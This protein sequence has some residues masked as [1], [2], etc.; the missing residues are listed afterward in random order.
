VVIKD[1]QLE[2]ILHKD[3]E[4]RV[5]LEFVETPQGRIRI[6]RVFNSDGTLVS[7]KAFL[8]EQPVP[9]PKK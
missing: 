3:R 8:N 7:E 9:V 5:P 6:E 4:G 2:R 1:H